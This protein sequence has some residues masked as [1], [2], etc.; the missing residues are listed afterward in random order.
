MDSNAR[1]VMNGGA[2][3]ATAVV[4][5]LGVRRENSAQTLSS[6]SLNSSPVDETLPVLY[7]QS[8]NDLESLLFEPRPERLAA[9][10]APTKAEYRTRSLK[11]FI[12]ADSSGGPGTHNSQDS[13]STTLCCGCF[14]TNRIETQT[15]GAA[16]SASR[17]STARSSSLSHIGTTTSYVRWSGEDDDE[18]ARRRGS[19]RPSSPSTCCGRSWWECARAILCAPCLLCIY[20]AEVCQ[21]NNFCCCCCSELDEDECPCVAFGSPSTQRSRTNQAAILHQL[22]MESRETVLT[23]ACH[24]GNV[25]QMADLLQREDPNKPNRSGDTP[26][27]IASSN[28]RAD[29]VR[30][31]LDAGA[32][33]NGRDIQGYT[34]LMRAAESGSV[35]VTVELLEAGADATA[36]VGD[37]ATALYMAARAGRARVVAELLKHLVE[38]RQFGFMDAVLRSSLRKA[39]RMG[40]EE[41]SLRLVQAGANLNG[42]DRAGM[43]P[44]MLA[45]QQGLCDVVAEMLSLGASVSMTS[46]YDG[47]TA[48][49]LACSH[50]H[51]FKKFYQR[52]VQLLIDAGADVRHQTADFKLTPVAYAV[53]AGNYAVV[54]KLLSAGADPDHTDGEG[55]TPLVRT[56]G[57]TDQSQTVSNRARLAAALI[58]GGADPNLA[59]GHG[60]T[61]L[62][63]AVERAHTVP[64]SQILI[65]LLLQ[66]GADR[67]RQSHA[68]RSAVDC[69]SQHSGHHRVLQ[70]YVPS[71]KLLS[72]AAVRAHLMYPVA[73]SIAELPIREPLKV[74]LAEGFLEGLVT[75]LEAAEFAAQQVADRSS[76]LFGDSAL[77]II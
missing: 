24:E 33:P 67:H 72:A 66:A 19:S 10:V 54:S 69:D 43:T 5:R 6:I 13:A 30:Q 8:N 17:T 56:L 4:D 35:D 61:P 12:K 11:R 59:D 2:P 42:Q 26:L 46:R 27:I 29:L 53:H 21:E 39:R 28:G 22:E 20:S 50:A 47:D 37:G 3:A 34:V 36:K 68:G 25:H 15:R 62:H 58:A 38:Q 77:E 74:F 52:T 45:A 64:E 57:S 65:M 73:C 14:F 60:R 70:S 76:A 75:A 23:K 63:A 71:L 1:T 55:L 51:H 40:L 32:D 44:L 49:T 48:L 41:L 9:S 31:L 18:I 16:S 7:E